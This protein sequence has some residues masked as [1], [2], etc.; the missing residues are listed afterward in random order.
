[1]WMQFIVIA[2]LLL[3]LGSLASG[4]VFLVRDGHESTRTVSA[5]TWRIGLSIACFLLLLLGML[6]GFVQPHGVGVG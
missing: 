4:L 3:I 5:L 6:L 1:M 2:L